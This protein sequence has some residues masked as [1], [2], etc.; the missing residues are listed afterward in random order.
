MIMMIFYGMVALVIMLALVFAFM[1]GRARGYRTG[2]EDGLSWSAE[3]P[4]NVIKIDEVVP[5]RREKVR[6]SMWPQYP[7]FD[8]PA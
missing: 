6:A 3:H 8:D 2:W 4:R 5:M 7:Y 1:V